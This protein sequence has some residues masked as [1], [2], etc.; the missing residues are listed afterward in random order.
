MRLTRQGDYAVR[1]M[2][3]LAAHADDGPVPRAQIQERQD[4]PAAYLA[5]DRRGIQFFMGRIQGRDQFLLEMYTRR[6]FT[7]FGTNGAAGIYNITL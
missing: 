6:A 7:R 2:V 4:V 1:V 5:G 3:D